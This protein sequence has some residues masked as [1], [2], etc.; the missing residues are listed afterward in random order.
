MAYIVNSEST[1]LFIMRFIAYVMQ[2]GPLCGPVG[3][4]RESSCVRGWSSVGMDCTQVKRVPHHHP[5]P[6]QQ[7]Q[8]SPEG[9]WLGNS[10]IFL[11]GVLYVNLFFFTLSFDWFLQ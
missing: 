7:P 5:A 4:G 10:D 1:H 8:T 11:P 2:T 9:R 3:R 6:G